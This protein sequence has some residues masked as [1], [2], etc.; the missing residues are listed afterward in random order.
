MKSCTLFVLILLTSKIAFNQ[1]ITFLKETNDTSSVGFNLQQYSHC[2]NMQDEIFFCAQYGATLDQIAFISKFSPNGDHLWTNRYTNPNAGDFKIITT[3]PTNDGGL[4]VSTEGYN[5]YRRFIFKIDSQ[6]EFVWIKDIGTNGYNSPNEMLV[7]SQN[8]TYV[9]GSGCSAGSIF[10]FKLNPDGNLLWYRW[11]YNGVGGHGTTLLEL[12]PNEILV[13]GRVGYMELAY[14]TIDQLGNPLDDRKYNIPGCD[15]LVLSDTKKLPNGE[16]II[17]AEYSNTSTAMRMAIIGKI[18]QDFNL[19]LFKINVDDIPMNGYS[20]GDLAI[21]SDGNII[22]CTA[23]NMSIGDYYYRTLLT[24]YDPNLNIISTKLVWAESHPIPSM[25]QNSSGN[26]DI[27]GK[28]PIP[29]VWRGFHWQRTNKDFYGICNDSTVSLSTEPININTTDD[30]I[31]NPSTITLIDSVLEKTPYTYAMNT[32][33][34]DTFYLNTEEVTPNQDIVIYPNP[35]LNEL[36]IEPMDNRIFS[37]KIYDTNGDVVH[38]LTNQSGISQCN[39][40]HLPNGLYFVHVDFVD[41]TFKTK[42]II[43]H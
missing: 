18:D 35:T 20:G 33:C 41:G 38:T 36:T 42:K 40:N 8:N 34:S 14:F 9:T 16:I 27:I 37:V 22:Q 26:I 15:W 19:Q 25:T 11:Y 13:T 12:S 4:I 3:A 5:V 43:K 17:S 30:I 7:D 1:N 39:I 23:F 10:V 29:W 32:I 28:P 6:G 31:S 24:K 21:D 2:I